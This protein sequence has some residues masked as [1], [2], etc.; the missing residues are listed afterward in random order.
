MQCKTGDILGSVHARL[1]VEGRVD[2]GVKILARW[3]LL[4]TSRYGCFSPG[5][6]ARNDAGVVLVLLT[7]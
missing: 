4:K 3:S 7:F 2:L 5:F 1:R 6:I